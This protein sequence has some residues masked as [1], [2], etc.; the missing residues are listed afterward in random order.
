MVSIGTIIAGCSRQLAALLPSPCK[1]AP[2]E[3]ISDEDG[4]YGRMNCGP[5]AYKAVQKEENN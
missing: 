1:T 2:K 4:S 3:E 5:G